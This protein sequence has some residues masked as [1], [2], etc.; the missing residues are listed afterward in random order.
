[1]FK[2]SDIV[3][4]KA[5]LV[6]LSIKKDE[7]CTF[8]DCLKDGLSLTFLA[9]ATFSIDI[10]YIMTSGASLRQSSRPRQFDI[11][12]VG[13]IS[14]LFSIYKLTVVSLIEFFCEL[15]WLKAK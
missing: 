1:M 7:V 4:E 5:I 3:R 12:G 13:D 6:L 8:H 10:L 9:I 11:D 15:T 14:I 2:A